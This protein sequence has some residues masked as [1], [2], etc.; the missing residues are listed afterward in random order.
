VLGTIIPAVQFAGMITPVSALEGSGRLIGMLHPA[1]YFLSISR[2]L[3][4]KALNLQD[5]YPAL[6]AMSLA[7]PAVLLLALWLLPKQER[8]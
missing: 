4:N 2:G 6:L 3:F 8:G 7:V 5:I 1:S